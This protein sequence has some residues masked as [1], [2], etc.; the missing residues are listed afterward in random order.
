MIMSF[1]IIC[2]VPQFSTCRDQ[3]NVNEWKIM[4]DPSIN[5]AGNFSACSVVLVVSVEIASVDLKELHNK[6]IVFACIKT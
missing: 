2:K 3:A 1:S 6:K 4:F 5:N